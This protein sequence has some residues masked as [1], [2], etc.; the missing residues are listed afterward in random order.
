MQIL[1]SRKSFAH[2]PATY[3]LCVLL[4]AAST[5]NN[6][7]KTVSDHA[8][9]DFCLILTS[10]VEEATGGQYVPT[11]KSSLAQIG[12]R[13]VNCIMASCKSTDSCK[14]FICPHTSLI[15]KEQNGALHAAKP[16]PVRRLYSCY[17][18][19]QDGT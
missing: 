10:F 4:G 19:D 8:T 11:R 2:Q 5:I 1:L 15:M 16:C 6:N 18:D 14:S 17:F 3:A 7:L 9:L 13:H 12:A